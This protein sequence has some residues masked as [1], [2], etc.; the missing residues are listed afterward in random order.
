VG[1][2]GYSNDLSQDLQHTYGDKYLVSRAHGNRM[3]EKQIF[4]AEVFPKEIIFER[5]H[6][7]GEMMELLKKGQVKFPLGSYDHIAWLIEHCASMELKPSMSRF[8]DPEIHYVKGSSP[9]DGLMG[10]L[11]AYIAYRFLLTKGFTIKNPHLMTV[12]FNTEKKPLIVI[13]HIARRF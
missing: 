9:N 7:I 10:L 4:N 5:D 8:G 13:G 3:K 6:Y 11:N 12:G 2:I 1:D